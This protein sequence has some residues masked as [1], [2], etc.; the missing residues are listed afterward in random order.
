MTLADKQVEI[1]RRLVQLA[2]EELEKGNLA[3]ASEKAWGAVTHRLKAIA[4]QRGWRHSDLKD[5]AMIAERL[6]KE[7]KHPERLTM[8]FSAGCSLHFNALN[9]YKQA[10][11]VRNDIMNVKML[12]A[13]LGGIPE[14]E[15]SL[16]GNS[17]EISGLLI[18][19]AEEY[20]EWG[21]PL[22]AMEKACEAVDNRLTAIAAQRGWES[23]WHVH[24]FKVVDQLSEEVAQ[25]EELK[26]M[27]S[28]AINMHFSLYN[29]LK[30]A[31]QVRSEIECAKK[32]LAMLEAVE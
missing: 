31:R 1:C 9:D 30:P 7:A 24:H 10:G 4:Q 16:E 29:E 13:M 27:F 15:V 32:L 20:L 21:T 23:G 22:Q 18:K 19:Q 5:Y 3:V 26:S 6:A 17:K 12:L 14:I 11:Q 28:A 25:P 2:D 8:L